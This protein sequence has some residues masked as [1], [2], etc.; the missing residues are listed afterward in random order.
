[1][2]T[3]T[4]VNSALAGVFALGVMAAGNA[5]AADADKEKCYGV[6]K[7]AK[8]DCGAPG[9]SCAGQA[10]KDGDA[11]EWVYVPKGLCD[12]LVG[13]TTTKPTT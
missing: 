8:N 6:V 7:A 1:M 9:H 11:N 5:V 13:G 2:K 4:A 10:T 3:K 12:K